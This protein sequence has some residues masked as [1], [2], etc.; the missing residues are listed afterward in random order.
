MFVRTNL[1]CYAHRSKVR[2]HKFQIS[3]GQPASIRILHALM[4][5]L[6]RISPTV[7]AFRQVPLT[8]TGLE[9]AS[10]PIAGLDVLRNAR[11]SAPLV[12]LNRLHEKEGV[13]VSV[14]CF[15]EKDFN[16]AAF[17]ITTPTRGGYQGLILT[18]TG[19]APEGMRHHAVLLRRLRS[20]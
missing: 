15:I 20:H 4:S 7:G 9:L 19:I 2:T 17:E 14:E 6:Q 3:T 16:V 5:R 8:L 18:K 12:P 11:P 1:A 10:Q 13:L